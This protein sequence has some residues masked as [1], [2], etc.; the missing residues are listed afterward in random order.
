VSWPVNSADAAAADDGGDIVV[1]LFFCCWL[2]PRLLLLTDLLLCLAFSTS[3]SD[4]ARLFCPTTSVC[5]LLARTYISGFYHAMMAMVAFCSPFLFLFPFLFPLLFL[6]P[7]LTFFLFPFHSLLSLS[8]RYLFFIFSLSPSRPVQADG[9]RQGHVC[10]RHAERF[11]CRPE[12][13]SPVRPQGLHGGPTGQREGEGQG[14]A[15][16]QGSF[17]LS[18]FLLFFPLPKQRPPEGL[19]PLLLLALTCSPAWVAGQR[20]QR[21][22]SENMPWTRGHAQADDMPQ[23]GRRVSLQA[24]AYGLL[25]PCRHPRLQLGKTEKEKKIERKKR[26]IE[27]ERERKMRNEEQRKNRI[28][29]AR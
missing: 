20:L 3:L 14:A 13:A 19:W 18:F 8:F 28:C 6:F 16:P 12:D 22:G 4:A 9:E 17:F 21:P 23:D 26:K 10:G 11:Q 29:R 15:H 7:F 24:E 5:R 2:L 1:F 27:R 25:A